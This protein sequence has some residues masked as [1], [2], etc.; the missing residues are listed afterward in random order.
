VVEETWSTLGHHNTMGRMAYRTKV[1]LAAVPAGKKAFLWVGS[2]DG[3]ARL[4][5][6]GQHVNYI[7]PMK[8]R[9]HEKGDEVEAFSGYCQPAQFDVTAVLKGGTNQITILCER[10]WLNELGTGGLMGPVVVYRKK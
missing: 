6:N 9:R 1:N 4:F 3:S 8:T 2:T 7:V 10:T 5:V